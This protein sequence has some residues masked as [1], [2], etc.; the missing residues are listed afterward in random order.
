MEGAPS[1]TGL[2]LEPLHATGRS[3]GCLLPDPAELGAV[4][5]GFTL[6]AWRSEDGG[7]L[8]AGDFL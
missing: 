7:M 2:P 5:E 3:V 4:Q 8:T 1:E 6:D